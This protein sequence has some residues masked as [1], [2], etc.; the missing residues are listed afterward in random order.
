MVLYGRTDCCSQN[1]NNF[2]VTVGIDITGANSA[3][4]VQ[5]GG[6]ISQKPRV[7]NKCEPVLKGRY[8]HVKMNRKT[9]I[10]L[11]EI[12]VYGNKGK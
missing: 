7:V 6:D 10:I 3:V 4:C 12:E 1:L 11:C 5:D 2:M 8:V 9:N